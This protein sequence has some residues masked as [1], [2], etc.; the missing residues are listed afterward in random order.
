MNILR[1]PNAR[2]AANPDER[3]RSWVPVER[4][5]T[6]IVEAIP[7]TAGSRRVKPDQFPACVSTPPPTPRGSP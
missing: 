6:S 5:P 4:A 1:E 3:R 7:S 2:S